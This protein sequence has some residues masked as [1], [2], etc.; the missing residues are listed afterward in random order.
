MYTFLSQERSQVCGTLKQISIFDPEVVI[1]TADKHCMHLIL[2][3][4]C[5]CRAI[6]KLCGHIRKS[7]GLNAQAVRPSSESCYGTSVVDILGLYDVGL[8]SEF[9]LMAEVGLL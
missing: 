6:S 5:T 4:L 3:T 2:H 8:H 7:A 9:S 1:I